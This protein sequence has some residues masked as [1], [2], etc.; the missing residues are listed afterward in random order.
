MSWYNEAG[1]NDAVVV[2]TRVRLARNIEGFPFPTGMNAEE[3]AKVIAATNHA[4][5]NCGFELYETEKIPHIRQ[6]SLLEKHLISPALIGGGLPRAVF[7]NGDETMAIMV[8][9]ED[10]LRI[11]C[12]IA[13]FEPQ[14]A[15]NIANDMDDYL[16]KNLKFQFHEKYGYLTSCPTNTGTGMRISSMLHLPAIALSGGVQSLLS[17]SAAAGMTVRGLFGE[18]SNASGNFFQVSNQITLGLDEEEIT[19]RFVSLVSAIETAECGLREQLSQ[20]IPPKLVDKITRA[21]G[22][23]ANAHMI[24]SG[25]LINL[26][27]DVRL[28]LY[29]GIIKDIEYK[30]LTELM[31]VTAPASIGC[32]GADNRDIKRAKMVSEMIKKG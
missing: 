9:E 29:L 20:N 12:I 2:S 23:M 3:G 22:V 4:L 17:Q 24:S 27:S 21:Y 8:N 15:Y 6:Q 16:T 25:E 18:G 26:I 1:S 13:G 10:H 14:K 7:V 19:K 30:K 32:D 11:Q 5:E 28:G 31:V